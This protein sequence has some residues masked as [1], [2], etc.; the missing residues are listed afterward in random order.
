MDQNPA[1]TQ[2][3]SLSEVLLLFG[4]FDSPYEKWKKYYQKSKVEKNYMN[5]SVVFWDTANR[6]FNLGVFDLALTVREA[7]IA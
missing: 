6:H 5:L 3:Y 2:Q 7:K 4:D 1:V